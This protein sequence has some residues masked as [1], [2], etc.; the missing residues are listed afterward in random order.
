MRNLWMISLTCMLAACATTPVRPGAAVPVP[1]SRMLAFEA[2]ASGDAAVVVARD[3]GFMGHGCGIVVSIDGTDA[4]IMGAGEE[5]TLYVAPGGHILGAH[6]S[7][8]GLCSIGGAAQSR[9]LKFSAG[10]SQHPQFRV[11]L[12]SSGD[13]A[14]TQT[15]L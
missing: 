1:A 2:P 5:A 12:L 14:V 7:N 9:T 4:A 6:S 3:A 10:A 11:G 15:A 13:I 8:K